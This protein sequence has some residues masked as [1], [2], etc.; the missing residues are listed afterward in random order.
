M[1]H[2]AEGGVH[3]RR[4]SPMGSPQS[5]WESEQFHRWGGGGRFYVLAN[6]QTPLRLVP[7]TGLRL[8]LCGR[9]PTIHGHERRSADWYS[10][11]VTGRRNEVRPA[12]CSVYPTQLLLSSASRT[13]SFPEMRS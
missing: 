3:A 1:D 9:S 10:V 7:R 6:G 13:R 5:K 8:Q 12:R 4:R 2:I 11:I